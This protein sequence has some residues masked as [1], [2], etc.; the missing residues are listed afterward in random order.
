MI[1]VVLNIYL[2]ILQNFAKKRIVRLVTCGGR[3]S[4]VLHRILLRRMFVLVG[5][6][7]LLVGMLVL[8]MRMPM[9]MVRLG[10]SSTPLLRSSTFAMTTFPY[11]YWFNLHCKNIWFYYI[12]LYSS[13][14]IF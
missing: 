12:S 7:M 11:I 9:M 6:L 1:D 8:F 4:D 14:S 2:Y 13:S 3:F 10:P 5:V